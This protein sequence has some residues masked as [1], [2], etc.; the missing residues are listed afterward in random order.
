M[1]IKLEYFLNEYIKFQIQLGVDR[2]M[3]LT[4]WKC[5][6]LNAWLFPSKLYDAHVARIRLHQ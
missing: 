1:P 4:L 6:V 2:F 5:K 3:E